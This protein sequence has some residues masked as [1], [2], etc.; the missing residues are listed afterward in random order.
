MKIRLKYLILCVI[1]LSVGLAL[2]TGIT[3]G[4]RVNQKSLIDNTLETNRVY[5]QKL[6]SVTENYI[7]STQQLLACSAKD[8]PS[9]FGQEDAKTLLANEAKRSFEQD[10]TFNSAI[11]TSASGEII[12]AFPQTLDIVGKQ[13]ASEGGRQALAEKKALIS[14]PYMSITGR[15]IIFIS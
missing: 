6:T 8:I 14:K 2:F 9:Y 15:L 1:L 5:A 11:I 13:V 3:A 4:Y 7:K 10:N 12:A